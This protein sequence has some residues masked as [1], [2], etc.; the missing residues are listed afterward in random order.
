[1]RAKRQT[2]IDIGAGA[3]GKV[4]EPQQNRINKVY[5]VKDIRTYNMRSE[6][7]IAKKIKAYQQYLEKI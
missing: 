6:E 3:T 7:I 2:I 5:T 4:Y 1:M